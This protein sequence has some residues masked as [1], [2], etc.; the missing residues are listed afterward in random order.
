[1]LQAYRDD[2]NDV[3]FN[4]IHVFKRIETSENWNLTWAALAKVKEGGFN[5]SAVAPEASEGRP[6]GNKAAKMAMDG[7]AG[8]ETPSIL[9][10]QVQRRCHR[11]VGTQGHSC[12]SKVGEGRCKVVGHVGQAKK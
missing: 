11:E 2:N 9:H 5:P 3:E 8:H 12:G 6:I 1:M 7:A 4:F 10:R